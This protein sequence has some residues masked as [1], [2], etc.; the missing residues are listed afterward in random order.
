MININGPNTIPADL[1]YLQNF[2]GTVS[3]S[4]CEF[5][6]NWI[7]SLIYVDVYSLNYPEIL[8]KDGLNFYPSQKHFLL[9]DVSIKN[10]YCSE[11]IIMYV[12]G[13]TLQNIYISNV[14]IENVHSGT[15]GVVFLWNFGTMKNSDFQESYLSAS[16]STGFQAPHVIS[17]NQLSIIK[18]DSGNTALTIYN[19]PLVE[20][21]D[22]YIDSFYDDL[23]HEKTVY[24]VVDEF[25]AAGKYFN[26]Y[27]DPSLLVDLNCK[28]VTEISNCYSLKLVELK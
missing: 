5:L 19:L 1:V 23:M 9:E 12:L 24:S 11:N 20:I 10:L 26:I 14:T 17:I 8:I 15:Y 16:Y 7:D 27:P 25:K 3:I 13:E 28:M 6:T 21:S 4:Q 2:L 18:S 22:L